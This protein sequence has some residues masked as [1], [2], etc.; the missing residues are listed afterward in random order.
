MSGNLF[1]REISSAKGPCL[2][3]VLEL[4]DEIQKLAGLIATADMVIVRWLGHVEFVI[5]LCP[6]CHR[7]VH[8]GADGAT[9]NAEL[10]ERMRRLKP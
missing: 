9:Y 10:L 3:A 5:S 2:I 8:A 1:A 6:N 7:R 4:L